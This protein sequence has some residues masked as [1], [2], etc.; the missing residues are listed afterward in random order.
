MI[1]TAKYLVFPPHFLTCSSRANNVQ[2]SEKIHSIFENRTFDELHWSSFD[3]IYA[4]NLLSKA[5]GDN[6]VDPLPPGL[7]NPTPTQ[8]A[9]LMTDEPFDTEMLDMLLRVP[10]KDFPNKLSH[11]HPGPY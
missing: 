11:T 8:S 5:Q 3:D 2:L 9:K 10:T 4:S 7:E 6:I 1:F